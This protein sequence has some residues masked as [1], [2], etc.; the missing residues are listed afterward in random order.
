VKIESC[1]TLKP[2]D[3][4]SLFTLWNSEYPK[5]ATFRKES[6]LVDYLN[7]LSLS[8]HQL[9]KDENGLLKAWFCT[10]QRIDLPW[11][12]MIV[13]RDLQ[14]KGWGR[15]FLEEAQKKHSILNGWA[16]D[17]NEYQ[18]VDGSPYPSP[19]GFYSKLGFRKTKLKLG[20]GNLS[21]VH[22]VWP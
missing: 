16:V 20:E 11:F 12:A 13:S 4:K 22:I 3:L 1:K 21:V 6:D 14:G 17:H 10:F 15:K 5:E 2:H 18:K 8:K 9:L 19:L 7:T